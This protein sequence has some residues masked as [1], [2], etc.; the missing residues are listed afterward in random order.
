MILHCKIATTVGV[1]CEQALFA[2]GLI[3]VGN[4]IFT[5]LDDYIAE[6]WFNKNVYDVNA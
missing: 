3:V 4:V 2:E 5:M 1:L 6:S